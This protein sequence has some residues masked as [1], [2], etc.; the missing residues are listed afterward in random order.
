[1]HLALRPQLADQ[2]VFN[3]LGVVPPYWEGTVRVSGFEN[4]RPVSGLGYVELVEI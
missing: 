1:M 2:E 3:S 4:G